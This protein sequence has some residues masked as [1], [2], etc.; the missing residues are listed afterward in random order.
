ML[1]NAGLINSQYLFFF[2][3]G[4]NKLFSVF[5]NPVELKTL[6][7]MLNNGGCGLFSLNKSGYWQLELVQYIVHFTVS[8]YNRDRWA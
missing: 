3:I 6:E 7:R 8:S 4:L 2:R 5:H 1:Y